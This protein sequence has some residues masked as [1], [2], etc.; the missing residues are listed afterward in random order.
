MDV[1][2]L[3]M[4]PESQLVLKGEIIVY[5]FKGNPFPDLLLPLDLAVEAF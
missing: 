5:V 1:G 3:A 4:Q 2:S